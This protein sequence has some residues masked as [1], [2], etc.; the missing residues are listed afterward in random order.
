[1][2]VRRQSW[3]SYWYELRFRPEG[4][5]SFAPMSPDGPRRV[6]DE[7]LALGTV[8]EF[9]EGLLAAGAD[10]LDDLRGELRVLVYTEAAPA[11]GTEPVLVRTVELGRH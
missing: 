2:R 8:G 6:P 9:A 1:M 3:Q 10:E 4:D 5:P 11:P 7:S